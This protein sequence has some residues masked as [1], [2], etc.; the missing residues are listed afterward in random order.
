MKIAWI[1]CKRCK[2]KTWHINSGIGI[3]WLSPL[4]VNVG[5]LAPPECLL[6]KFILGVTQGCPVWAHWCVL[7]I[8]T[9][10]IFSSC[11]E[12]LLLLKLLIGT[13]PWISEVHLQA[14]HDLLLGLVLPCP[15][16]LLICWGCWDVPVPFLPLC[17]ILSYGHQ[18]G[19]LYTLLPQSF[20]L[21]SH[22]KDWEAIL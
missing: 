14:W 11:S 7:A 10:C 12:C 17:Y 15:D 20:S 1:W 8:A 16:V 6:A 19:A 22:S 13:S 2:K 18:S 4:P 21:N 3:S 9:W 5:A